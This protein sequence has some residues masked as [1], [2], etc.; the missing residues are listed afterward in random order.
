MP[1]M[2]TASRRGA[3]QMPTSYQTLPNYN[4][5]SSAQSGYDSLEY[6]TST[7][8]APTHSPL[9]YNV[10]TAGRLNSIGLPANDDKPLTIGENLYYL[11]GAAQWAEPPARLSLPARPRP[12]I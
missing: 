10:L 5:P 11:L 6:Q 1:S 9:L 2:I 4:Q 12:T 3:F 7:A 8:N